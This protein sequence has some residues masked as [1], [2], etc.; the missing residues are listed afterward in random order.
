M[1]A[2]FSTF[3]SPRVMRYGSVLKRRG[4][5]FA[6]LFGGGSGQRRSRVTVSRSTARRFSNESPAWES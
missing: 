2:F 3:D 4:E 5:A 6:G 1:V